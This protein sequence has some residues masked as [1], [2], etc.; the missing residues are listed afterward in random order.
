MVNVT[1]EI[2]VLRLDKGGE[3][4]IFIFD[5]AHVTDLLQT[6]G[7][8]AADQELTFTWYDAARLSHEVRSHQ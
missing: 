8:W 5:R 3:M 6:F 7:R 2:H 4:W 1:E